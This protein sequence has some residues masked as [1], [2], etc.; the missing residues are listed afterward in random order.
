M[1]EEFRIELVSLR[2][3]ADGVT[4]CDCRPS[5]YLL[6][7]GL[8]QSLFAEN[9]EITE[10]TSDSDPNSKLNQLMMTVVEQCR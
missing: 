9:K 8:I 7:L 4:W 6:L 10:I 5:T 2:I 1:N 3:K